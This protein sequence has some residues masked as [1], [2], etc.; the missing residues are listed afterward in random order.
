M[1]LGSENAVK[2]SAVRKRG[3]SEP[4]EQS[5]GHIEKVSSNALVV[6]PADEKV[7]LKAAVVAPAQEEALP[8][9]RY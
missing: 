2:D 6:A 7:F 8:I 9:L 5:S 3:R 4:L 1:R